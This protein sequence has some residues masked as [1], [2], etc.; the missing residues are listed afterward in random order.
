MEG[1]HVLF[2]ILFHGIIHDVIFAI[3]LNSISSRS[4][5]FITQE[6]K[7]LKDHVVKRFTSPSLMSCGQSCLK[8]AWC[9]SVN[10]EMIFKNGKGTCELNSGKISAIDAD[11][12]LHHEQGVIFS[13]KLKDLVHDRE[14]PTLPR[15]KED[16]T[17]TFTGD[18][19]MEMFA[20]G[21]SLGKDNEDWI[22]AT[23][24]IIPENTRL[25]SIKAK[26]E[27]L[28]HYGILGSFSNGLVT[29]ESWKCT[30]HFYLGWNIPHLDDSN[31]PAAVVVAKH[32]DSPWGTIAGISLTA[33][34]IW[35]AGGGF[36]I[37]YCR[38]NLS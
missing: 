3:G 26:P 10:F 9:T 27:R 21:R 38:L 33:K 14:N 36:N 20:D 19:S 16:F 23:N 15:P 37:V 11:S 32:G 24:F 7:R 13:M 34:W 28:L 22:K 29:N 4:A 25:I 12:K 2:F 35:A 5:Y 31:W 30:N 1:K 8:H 18:D 17:A 6:N